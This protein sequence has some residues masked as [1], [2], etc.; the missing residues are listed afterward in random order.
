MSRRPLAALVALLVPFVAAASARADDVDRCPDRVIEQPFVPWNDPFHYFLAPDGDF[1][2]GGAGWT[3]Q[4][5]EVVDENE[6]YWVHGGDTAASLRLAS[7]AA[8][9]SPWICVGLL[10]PTLRFFARSTGDS[11]ELVVTVRL[12]TLLGLELAL[13]IGTVDARSAG[14]WVPVPAMLMAVNALPGRVALRFEARG[15]AEWLVDDVYVDP[16]RKG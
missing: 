5:A 8:A 12:R 1:S 6:P 9:T 15:E 11:G 4:G 10:D 14:E 2:A 7:G 3:L 16:Y 13:P